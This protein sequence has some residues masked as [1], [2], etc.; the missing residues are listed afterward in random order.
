V[1]KAHGGE[2]VLGHRVLSGRRKGS[3]RT[4]DRGDKEVNC[5]KRIT[6]WGR[7]RVSAQSQMKRTGGVS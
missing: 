5:S 3:V 7:R 4:S 6:I 2:G 1:S